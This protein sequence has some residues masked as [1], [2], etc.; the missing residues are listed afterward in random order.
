LKQNKISITWSDVSHPHISIDTIDL[1]S[2]SD[3][4]WLSDFID[5]IRSFDADVDLFSKEFDDEFRNY[6]G[7]HGL[8]LI[9]LNHISGDPEIDP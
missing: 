7:A 4:N 9:N 8:I 3:R 6:L 2:G 1:T 5:Y